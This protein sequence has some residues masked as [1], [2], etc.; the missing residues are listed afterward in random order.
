MGKHRNI[1]ATLH[2]RS[3]N[4]HTPEAPQSDQDTSHC[5]SSH[6]EP[7]QETDD[8]WTGYLDDL[9]LPEA[10]PS[11]HFHIDFRFVRGSDFKVLKENG[12]GPT[13]TSVDAKNSYCLIVDR[14]T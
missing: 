10:L 8:K 5:G 12:K 6:D 1:G 7:Q 13:L 11:Q 14:T 2:E 9:H 4:K 3:Q